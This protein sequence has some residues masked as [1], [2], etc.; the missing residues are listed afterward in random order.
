[1]QDDDITQCADCGELI[2]IEGA[3]DSGDGYGDLLCE[4]CADERGL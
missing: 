4:L 2:Y 3:T 1:M